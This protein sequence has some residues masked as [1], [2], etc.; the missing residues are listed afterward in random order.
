MEQEIKS[1]YNSSL[2]KGGLMCFVETLVRGSAFV[3]RMNLV[4]KTPPFAKLQNVVHNFRKKMTFKDIKEKYSDR[5]PAFP[6]NC[7]E[8]NEADLNE[9]IEKYNCKFPKSFIDFQLK[10]CKEVPIGDFAFEGFGFANKK[11]EPNMNLEEVLKDYAEL[12]FPEYLTPF[13]QDN[14][15][16]WCFDN[17]SINS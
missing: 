16:F 3:L 6:S 2:A 10:F 1:A 9:L 12:K 11:L 17:R 7:P 13:R 15:D 4:L 14:G 8:P 5:E